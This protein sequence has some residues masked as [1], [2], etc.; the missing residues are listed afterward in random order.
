MMLSIVSR[1]WTLGRDGEWSLGNEKQ[2]GK[3][4]W[5]L[6]LIVQGEFLGY[7]TEKW[8]SGR[9]WHSPW[10]E[11]KLGAQGGK[12]AYSPQNIT[13]GAEKTCTERQLKTSTLGL[14]QVLLSMDP[15]TQVKI[16]LKNPTQDQVKITL[17]N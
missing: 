15:L 13:M 4:S 17:K 14:L 8:N 6:Q 5:F 3:S 9:A 7:C 2:W 16:I 1:Q 12:V 11:I 10:V